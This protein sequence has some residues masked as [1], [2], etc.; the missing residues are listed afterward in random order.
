MKKTVRYFAIDGDITPFESYFQC[1]EH[2]E[3]YAN[4]FWRRNK[5]NCEQNAKIHAILKK[6]VRYFAIVGDI[7]PFESYF[8]A[9]N[10]PNAMQTIFTVETSQTVGKMR[11]FTRF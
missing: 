3:C 2:A 11:P 5:P 4:H 10:T 6:T 1:I 7:S 8:I 9:F